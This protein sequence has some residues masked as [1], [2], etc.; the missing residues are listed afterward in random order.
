MNYYEILG[1]EP[2]AT[3]VEISKAFK[4]KAKEC[5][6]D[7]HPDDPDATQKFAEINEAYQVLSDPEKKAAYD[8]KSETIDASEIFDIFGDI[9]QV[10]NASFFF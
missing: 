4:K 6:P 5:H 7:T 3:D 1:V 9:L 10:R 8:G 2:T